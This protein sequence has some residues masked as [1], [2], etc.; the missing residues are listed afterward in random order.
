M[1]LRSENKHNWVYVGGV[2]IEAMFYQQLKNMKY[3]IG[4]LIFVF[5]SWQEQVKPNEQKAVP[6]ANSI[7][8]I[9]SL[10]SVC[11]KNTI[12]T[13]D[14]EKL[15][16]DDFSK[17]TPINKKLFQTIY[18]NRNGFSENFFFI[19]SYLPSNNDY[20]SLITYQKNY[21][22]EDYR[23]D[24]IDLVNIDST[25]AQLDKIRLAAKDNEVITY[26]VVSYLINDTLI[27]VERFSS[28]SYFNPDM[29]TLYT[30]HYILKLNGKNRID[31]LGIKKGFEVWKN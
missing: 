7:S 18:P 17:M 28:E 21:E 23:V 9:D 14:I 11:K 26:E 10:K 22:G 16:T 12:D 13:F 29:D 2:F 8:L 20:L 24:Y 30:N 25:G 19:Y 3:T 1:W 6:E 27:V 31:T 4:L 5:H 15:E